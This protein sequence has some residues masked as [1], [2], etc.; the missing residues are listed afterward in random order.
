MR[1]I[2]W[3]RWSGG[4]QEDQASGAKHTPDFLEGARV[5]GNVL[6]DFRAKHEI[7]LVIRKRKIDKRTF[8]R[9]MSQP[10]RHVLLHVL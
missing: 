4:G 3:R 2:V 10:W 9:F 7:E 5:I 8:R 1:W 6:E